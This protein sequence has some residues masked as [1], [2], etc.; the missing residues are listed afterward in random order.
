MDCRVGTPSQIREIDR[1]AIEEYGLPGVVLMESAGAG[2][3]AIALEMLP[4]TSGMTALVLCGKGANG[5]DGFVIARRLHNAGVRAETLLAAR[6]SDIPPSSDAGVHL[7]VLRRMGL[8]LAEVLTVEEAEAAAPRLAACDLIV[9][10]L[11]GTGLTGEVRE[12]IRTLIELAG[13]CGR[14]VLAVDTPSGLCGETG[15]VLGAALKATRTATFAAAKS[16]FFAGSGPALVGRL[17]VVDIGIPREL[18]EALDPM[19]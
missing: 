10:A 3:A 2:A 4:A 5:G 16:G 14:P 6:A 8:P 15:R 7:G 17:D 19:Q 13:R 18:L 1:R 9:D 11:L 12:P